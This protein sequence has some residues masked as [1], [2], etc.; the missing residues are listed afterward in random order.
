MPLHS[1]HH[2]LRQDH[3]L[4][5]LHGNLGKVC[6]SVVVD[7]SD[8]FWRLQLL[9]GISLKVLHGNLGRVA[10]LVSCVFECSRVSGR[11]VLEIPDIA[12]RRLG[13]GQCQNLLMD[14]T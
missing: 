2:H 13:S 12:K 6:N 3:R 9:F 10:Y 4:K 7:I 5:V 1:H 8:T 11:G 14:L